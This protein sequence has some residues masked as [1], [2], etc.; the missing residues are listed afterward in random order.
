MERLLKSILTM[1]EIKFRMDD[2]YV[3]RLNRQ[4]TVI[5]LI[6]FGDSTALLLPY[7]GPKYLYMWSPWSSANLGYFCGRPIYTGN[8][9]TTKVATI[10][11]SI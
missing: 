2:D 9:C 8:R 6:F 11:R 5:V 4:Y 7:L 10:R 3:D 1:R